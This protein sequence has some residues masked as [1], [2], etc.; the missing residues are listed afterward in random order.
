MWFCECKKER[1]QR[2]Q[3]FLE[4]EGKKNNE[5]IKGETTKIY[6][7]KPIKRHCWDN[8]IIII[9]FFFFWGWWIIGEKK[10]CVGWLQRGQ[11]WLLGLDLCFYSLYCTRCCLALSFTLW[12]VYIFWGVFLTVIKNFW[13]QILI[14]METAIKSGKYFRFSVFLRVEFWKFVLFLGIIWNALG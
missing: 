10:F 4:R 12:L 2:E 3:R 5:K 13:S 9:I 8:E 1:T 11:F 7:G 14:K 6:W